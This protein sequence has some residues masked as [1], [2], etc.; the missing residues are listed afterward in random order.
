ML[1][2][3]ISPPSFVEVVVVLC[4]LNNNKA[5]GVDVVTAEF[6]KFGGANAL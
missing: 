2:V 3:S 4:S 6:L 5:L 1:A